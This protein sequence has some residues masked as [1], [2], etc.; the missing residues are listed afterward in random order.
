[1]IALNHEIYRSGLPSED[2][3]ACTVVLRIVFCFI[4]ASLNEM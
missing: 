4:K 3:V 1:M 2:A